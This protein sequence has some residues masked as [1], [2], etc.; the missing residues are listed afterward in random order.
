LRE[1]HIAKGESKEKNSYGIP[2]EGTLGRGMGS[3]IYGDEIKKK[4]NLK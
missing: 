1:T 3:T 4:R 2:S